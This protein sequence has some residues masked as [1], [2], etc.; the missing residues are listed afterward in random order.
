M[1]I[2]SSYNKINPLWYELFDALLL[3][4][5]EVKKIYK[6]FQSMSSSPNK[7]YITVHDLAKKLYINLN[8]SE[9]QSHQSFNSSFNSIPSPRPPNKI[10]EILLNKFVLLLDHNKNGEIY[11][12]NFIIILW[13]YLSLPP[14][15]LP[16]FAFRLYQTCSTSHPNITSSTNKSSSLSSLPSWIWDSELCDSFLSKYEVIELLEDVFGKNY[17]TNYLALNAE[18]VLFSCHTNDNDEIKSPIIKDEEDT[19]YEKTTFTEDNI[20][21][22]SNILIDSSKVIK[23]NE[24][25]EEKIELPSDRVTLSHFLISLKRFPSLIFP[26]FQLQQRLKEYIGGT[27]FWSKIAKRRLKKEFNNTNFSSTTS[28]SSSSSNNNIFM[29]TLSSTLS[30]TTS[31][32]SNILSFFHSNSA[33]ISPESYHN[34]LSIKNFLISHQKK[35]YGQN[36]IELSP[37]LRNPTILSPSP[38]YNNTNNSFKFGRKLSKDYS[39]GPIHV[40]DGE[41]FTRKKYSPPTPSAS[42]LD[43]NKNK[44]FEELNI[45][46]LQKRKKNDEERTVRY[47]E[48]VKSSSSS[49]TSSISP[50][51]SPFTTSLFTKSNIASVSCDSISSQSSLSNYNTP[52]DINLAS[53]SSASVAN[54]TVSLT[55]RLDQKRRELL[56]SSYDSSLC[57]STEDNSISD[58]SLSIYDLESESDLADK[59]KALSSVLP[60]TNSDNLSPTSS[61]SKIAPIKGQIRQDSI[62]GDLPNFRNINQKTHNLR[63]HFRNSNQDNNYNNYSNYSL[64]STSTNDPRR[65][66]Y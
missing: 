48:K 45:H 51:S 8:S 14:E 59:F 20:S 60:S 50:P 19:Y 2:T 56:E 5:S 11:F 46:S 23:F 40:N 30:S 39:I 62:V 4:P 49:L 35:K 38:A 1:G 3:K 25:F 34:N 6:I 58:L 21:N 32:T 27:M 17:S 47:K 43:P 29:S 57:T 44:N 41:L 15:G 24:K 63:K 61:S 65:Y 7:N 54:S 42:S 16:I 28:S 18:N 12:P 64:A 33:P 55:P 10:D 53:T 52:R 31:T 37:I 13:V 66:S 26:V 9:Y 22:I 36:Y